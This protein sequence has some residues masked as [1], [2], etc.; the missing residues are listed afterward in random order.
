MKKLFLLLLLLAGNAHADISGIVNKAVLVREISVQDVRDIY[1]FKERYGPNGLKPVLFRMNRGSRTHREFVTQ[2][3][4]T[5]E[6]AFELAWRKNINAGLDGM[7]QTAQTQGVML[8]KVAYVTYG[9]GYIDKDYLAVSLSQG[10]VI[11]VRIKP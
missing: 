9:V 10:E 8:D 1:T 7:Y 4:G 3:L 5:T 11:V 2:V 6:E